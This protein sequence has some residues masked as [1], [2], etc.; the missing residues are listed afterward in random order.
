MERY[1][2]K[3]PNFVVDYD[4]VYNGDCLY[5]KVYYTGNIPYNLRATIYSDLHNYF[6]KIGWKFHGVTEYLDN[7]EM[8]F[9]YHKKID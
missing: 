9:V 3:A 6:D 4:T 1:L 8:C 2:K 7:H 5:V